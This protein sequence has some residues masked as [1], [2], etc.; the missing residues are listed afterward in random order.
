MKIAQLEQLHLRAIREAD[1]LFLHAPD[2]HI[3]VSRSFEIGYAVS[4][5]IPVISFEEISDDMLRTII[6]VRASVF[7]ALFKL[8]FID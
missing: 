7:D 5:N 2:G 8:G 6:A 1:V 3:G 4:R